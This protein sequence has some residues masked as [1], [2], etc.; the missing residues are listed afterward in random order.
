[1]NFGLPIVLSAPSGSGKSTLAE[2][3]LKSWPNAVRSISCT[4]RK[5][6]PNE[7][8]NV[9]YIFIN[10]PEFNQR[11]RKNEFVEWAT[12]HGHMYGTPKVELDK[13]ILAKKDVLLVI[14]PQGAVNIKKI[15]PDGVFIFLVPPSWD[16]LRERL[17]KRASEPA[18]DIETRIK[19]A[20]FELKY[21]SFFQYLVLNEDL[22][23]AVNDMLAIIRAEHCRVNHVN[24]KDYPFLW[25]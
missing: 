7:V 23:K 9:D 16:A 5:P 21:L 17:E 2:R 14:D 3:F 24:K 20:R 1:M 12:V 19:D 13:N 18:I 11:V 4:T 22:D 10:E 8:N 15:Y 6:R 25:P